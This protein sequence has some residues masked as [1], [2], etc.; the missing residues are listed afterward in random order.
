MPITTI[1]I[2]IDKNVFQIHEVDEEVNLNFLEKLRWVTI[3]PFPRKLTPCLSSMEA[4][5]TAHQ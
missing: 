2:A 4:C 1:G 5:A 3:P